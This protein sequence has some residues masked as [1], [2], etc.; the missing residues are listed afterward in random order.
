[1]GGGGD[2]EKATNLDGHEAGILG[3]VVLHVGDDPPPVSH[4]HERRGRGSVVAI[5][6][7]PGGRLEQGEEA[8]SP[9]APVR[10][11]VGQ[12]DRGCRIASQEEGRRL[13]AAVAVAFGRSCGRH[14]GEAGGGDALEE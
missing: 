8:V 13:G 2:K 6:D 3:R 1:M 7:A 10:L 14:G 12:L 9:A 11:V 5:V 4:G